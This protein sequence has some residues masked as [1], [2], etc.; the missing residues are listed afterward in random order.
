MPTQESTPSPT[1]LP[2]PTPREVALFI[3]LVVASGVASVL[4]ARLDPYLATSVSGLLGLLFPGRIGRIVR[5]MRKVMGDRLSDSEALAA[6]RRWQRNKIEIQL[7]QLRGIWRPKVHAEI[8]I[9]GQDHIERSLAKGKGVILW[10]ISTGG[11]L[12][13]KQGLWLAGVKLVHLTS[14]MHGALRKSTF[15]VG[16]VVP[17]RRRA[18][19]RYVAERVTIPLDGSL[20]YLITL[21][22]RLAA[23]SCVTIVGEYRGRQNVRAPLFSHFVDFAMG[24]P[25]LSSRSGADLL[26]VYVERQSG[27]RYRM[28]VEEPIEVAGADRKD[29]V[30]KAIAVFAM[31]L[32]RRIEAHPELWDGWGDPPPLHSLPDG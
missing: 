17:F 4:P 7:G 3:V 20:N 22:E 31:R 15:S 1:A 19:D 10:V 29:F 11:P 30:R 14:L 23:N 5:R 18:E 21:K 32:E 16:R 6:A 24:A 9:M 27:G 8:E 12:L 2:G 13:Y 28:V 26:T 25:S